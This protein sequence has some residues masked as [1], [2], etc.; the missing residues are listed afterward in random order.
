[1]GEIAGFIKL[2]AEESSD[3]LSVLILS[4]HMLQTSFMRQPLAMKTG[5]T[6]RDI[7]ETIHAHPTLAEGIR[8]IC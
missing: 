4:D 3:K 7:A 5:L 2:I 8:G 6:I 1:M